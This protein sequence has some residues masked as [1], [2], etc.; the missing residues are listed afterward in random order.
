MAENRIFSNDTPPV[1]RQRREM[2]PPGSSSRP[3]RHTSCP[4]EGFQDDQAL[5]VIRSG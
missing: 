2:E 3:A 1:R 4:E 5:M